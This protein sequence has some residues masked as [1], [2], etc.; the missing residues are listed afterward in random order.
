MDPNSQ[1]PSC[2]EP[3]MKTPDFGKLLYHI[4]YIT[5]RNIYIH[6]YVICNTSYTVGADLRFSSRALR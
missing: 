4:L 6:I 2:K 3:K 1:D 5:Y